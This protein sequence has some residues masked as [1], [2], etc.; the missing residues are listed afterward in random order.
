MTSFSSARWITRCLAAGIVAS[1]GIGAALAAPGELDNGFG[2]AGRVRI[3]PSTPEGGSPPQVAGYAMAQQADGKIVVVGQVQD[4]SNPN[5]TSPDFGVARLNTDGSLDTS[6]GDQGAL[7][8][9]FGGGTAWDTAYAVLIQP[10][11]KIVVAGETLDQSSTYTYDVALVRLNA[12]G[13]LDT[14]FGTGGRVIYDSGGSSAD[15]ATGIVRQTDGSLVIAGNTDR[16]GEYDA[17]FARFTPDGAPDTTFG[18]NGSVTL[19]FGPGSTETVTA[20]VRLS[21]DTLVAA[22]EGPGGSGQQTM[23][24]FRLTKDGQPDTTFSDDGLVIVNFGQSYATARAAVLQTDGKLVLA[25]YYYPSGQ[26]VALARLNTD[27]SLDTDFGS[28]GTATP[29]LGAAWNGHWANGVVVQADGSIV[30]AGGLQPADFNL[31]HDLYLARLQADGTL[32][33]TFGNQ[34]VAIADFGSPDQLSN[35]SANALL[36]Q[37]DG[38]LVAGGTLASGT[39]AIFARFDATGGGSGGVLSFATLGTYTQENAGTI[40]VTLRRTGGGTGPV[41]ASVRVGASASG[42]GFGAGAG[43]D[44]TLGSTTVSWGNGD[45]ADKTIS[46]DIVDDAYV[47]NA[48]NFQIQLFA[49]VGAALAAD[50]HSVYINYDSSDTTDPVVGEI[51]IEATKTVS[52]GAGTV[53]LTVTR[54]NGSQDC[55][56]ADYAAVKADFAQFPAT[57]GVDFAATTGVVTFGEGDTTPKQISI[58]IIEDNVGEADE[59][60]AVQLNTSFPAAGADRALVTIQDND[61][62]YPGTLSFVQGGVMY[63][64]SAGTVQVQLTRQDG[65]NGEVSVN[66]TITSGTATVGVDLTGATSG[67]VT[68]AA[69]DTATKVINVTIV[70]DT[71]EES[72]ETFDITLSGATNGAAVG[73]SATFTGQINDNDTKYPGYFTISSCQPYPLLEG[74]GKAQCQV[75]RDGGKD[76]AVSVSFA[77]ADGT[78]T[79]PADYQAASGTLNWADG[80]GC[81]PPPYSDCN[82]RTKFID[83]PIVDDTDPEPSETFDIVLSNPTNG[84]T[85]Q[86]GG[87]KTTVTIFASD[88]PAGFISMEKGNPYLSVGEAAG[89]IT[90]HALRT[91]GT[92]GQV[93]VTFFTLTSIGS[94]WA[95]DG[96]DFTGVQPPITLTWADGDGSPK[97]VVIPILD[98]ANIEGAEYFYVYLQDATGGAVLDPVYFYGVVQIIDDELNPGTASFQI[99]QT[100]GESV[101]TFNLQVFRVLGSSGAVSVNW[102]ANN[103]T[104]VSP[105]DF[106][107]AGS[108]TLS[109]A[110]GEGGSKLI[111]ITI[112]NDT[113]T[114]PLENFSIVFSGATGGLQL[115][116][117]TATI[118]ILDDD[119][120][121]AINLSPTQQSVTEADTTVTFNATRSG[122]TTGAV[123]VTWA[124]AD[125]TAT[126][127]SDYLQGGATLTWAAGETGS[128]SFSVTIKDD[129]IEELDETFAVTLSNPTGGAELQVA[130][131]TGTI[132]DNDANPGTL[133][134]TVATAQVSEAAGTG[135]VQIDV[136]RVGGSLGAVGVQATTADGTALA[137]S[138]YTAPLV[139]VPLAWADGE[140][141]TRSFTIPITNDTVHEQDEDFTVVLSSPTGG[142]VLGVPSTE[143]VTIQNDDDFNGEFSLDAATASVTEGGQVTLHVTRTNGSYGPVTVDVATANGAAV[144]PD[145]FTAVS[146]T[147]SW[148]AGDTSTRTVTV[149]TV[150]DATDEPAENFA[151][152][153]SNATGGGTIYV[154]TTNVTIQDNDL[155]PTGTIIMG[156]PTI[157]IGE[158][159]S[160]VHIPVGRTGG[161][162]G[163]ATV[164]YTTQD[165]TALAGSDY[166]A[167]SGTLT[168]GDWE[169]AT[170]SIAITINN[171]KIDE[172]DE[173]F[174]VVLSNATG[175][176]LSATD[177]TTAVTIVDDDLPLVPGELTVVAPTYVDENATGVLFTFRRQGGVD[178]IVSVDYATSN[179]TA[180]AGADYTAKSG[181]LTWADGDGADQTVL[182]P[183][184]DDI[185]DEPNETFAMAMSNP[186]GGATLGAS[187]SVTM[188]IVDND[189]SGPGLLGVTGADVFETVGNAVIAVTRGNGFD[190]AVGVTVSTA[191]G[192]ALAGEDYTTTSQVLNWADGEGG[193]KTVSIPITNDSVAE[194]FTENFLVNLSAGTGG[195]T[196]NPA[197]AGVTIRD[198]DAPGTIALTETAVLAAENGPAVQLFV[199]RS[200]GAK[201][202]VSVDFATADGTA[203]AGTDYTSQSGTL[204]WLDGDSSIRTITVPLVDDTKWEVDETF[205]VVLSN[206]SPGAGLGNA[207]ATVTIHSDEV[208]LPGTLRMI[209]PTATVAE[210][211]GTVDVQ[212]ERINGSDGAISVDY[213]TNAGTATAG[214]DY[215]SKSNT[216]T[217]ADGDTATK[218]ITVAILDDAAYEPDET[219]AVLLS[220]PQGGSILAEAS[221]VVTI[222]SEDVAVPGTLGLASATASVNEPAG[223]VTLLVNRTGG[224]DTA[225]SVGYTTASGTA[226]EGADFTHTTGTLNW[227]DGDAAPKAIV[228]PIVDDATYEPVDETFTVTLG[229]VT[230]ATLGTSAATVTIVSDD[231]PQRGTLAMASAAASVNEPDGT[232][233]VLVNRTGGSDGP[234]SVSYATTAGSAG[235]GDYTDTSGTLSWADG[236]SSPKPIAVSITN[237]AIFE[238]DETFT[239]TLSAPDG[240][241]ALGSLATTTVTIV[242]DDAPLGGLIAMAS[243]TASVNEP[244]GTITLNVNRVGGADGAVSVDY[245]T[246]AGTATAGADYTTASGTLS[247]A[248]GDTAAKPITVS[249]GN[250]AKYEPDETFTVTLANLVG[251]GS[252]LGLATTT[253]TIVSEDPVQPGTIAMAA[254]SAVVDETQ[255][256]ITLTVNRT[257]GTDGAVGVNYTMTPV[258][259]SAADFTISSGTL[260]WADGD[261]AAKTI[262]VPITNDTAFEPDETFTVALAGE[263]GGATLGAATTTVTIVSD[264]PA[265]RGTLAL[266]SATATVNEADGTITL[267]VDRTGG[268]DGV[269]SVSYATTAG[270][271]TSADFTAASGTLTWQDGDAATRTIVVQISNDALVEADEAFAVTLSNQTGGA[272]LGRASTTVTI[273]DDDYLTVPGVLTL[274]Q[275]ATTVSETTTTVTFTVTRTGGVG[276]AVSVDY[277]TADGTAAAGSDYTGAAGTLNWPNGDATSRTFTVTL[278][279]DT[280]YE[281]D[282]TF[283]VALSGPTGSVVLGNASATVTIQSEDPPPDTTPEPFSFVDQDDQEL[284]AEIQSNQ[285]AV[286]GINTPVQISITGGEYSVN[287]GPYT[288]EPGT[289]SN[290]A[291]VRVRVNSSANYATT[292][293]ATLTIGGVSDT[294]TVTTRPATSPVTVRAKGGGGSL[295]LLEILFGAGLLLVRRRRV[296]GALASL[297][298]VG[299]ALAAPAQAE[300]GGFY[301]AVGVGQSEVSVSQSEAQG[302][303]E[304]ATGA[305]ITSM[306][307][308]N[309]DTS[310]QGRVGF[311]FNRVF[312]IEAAYYDFGETES[313]INAN[314]L[315]AQEFVDAVADAFP[316]NTHGPA[317]LLRL[318]WPF[319]DKFA[320]EARAGVLMWNSSIDARV[321]NGGSEAAIASRDGTDPIFG[322]GFSWQMGK[323]LGLGLEYTQAQLD[324]EVRSYALTVTW[325]L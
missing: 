256:T 181:T 277:A 245:A 85:L 63:P 293:S 50:T 252:S 187:S 310:F 34:G 308:D 272:T 237:D 313:E 81:P 288:S 133:R 38:R 42:F 82:G 165:F 99:Q 280:A 136:E 271:A 114:E 76:G 52:E 264:D 130:S 315:D 35:A 100:V 294:F 26:A 273:V 283:T 31:A 46:I 64:E 65:S 227:A 125:G 49:P 218:T 54:S 134:F 108:G 234:V 71:L 235:A 119:Y 318:A 40:T 230:G 88:P 102:T 255:G 194:T 128:K 77:T 206:V 221:T 198:D 179:G 33:T 202:T 193:T 200:N 44:F 208:P 95:Q 57:S 1:L 324:D 184:N 36:L 231:P 189:F 168:W 172:P 253:V 199:A 14:S 97:D 104:A 216:L 19:T 16:N 201:G 116:N 229:A 161:V 323:H 62:G 142:A 90:V 58:P 110:A 118:E 69:G 205:D 177:N 270:T 322:V 281:S 129:A 37:T 305:E 295:G 228:V 248:N 127:P 267:N 132:V 215:T 268:T 158:N 186:Q 87:E 53:T 307:F 56:V 105:D 28:G 251:A 60:F 135:S 121:G 139:P 146:Q 68:W 149:D 91:G 321:I 154:D 285:V 111:P 66:Y 4:Y 299:L 180:T 169:Y 207:A 8:I 18:T 211:A 73:Y 6:F 153:L 243:A 96:Q 29:D 182:V 304:A 78:A 222:Q 260:S 147:L 156:A 39:A 183:V 250:D 22:G 25:G 276:G 124:T 162:S 15:R 43:C 171:D 148:A 155:G 61:G 72:A 80:E 10:D 5:N 320:V 143:T 2:I 240:G 266:E 122:G 210:T 238:A 89:S 217:W 92:Q 150:D 319:A 214:S 67:T 287:G 164:D 137:G 236:D 204:T 70:D 300:G 274:T 45:Y 131:A 278:I 27:G 291:T 113:A 84:A 141:G 312:G 302:R 178:G 306:S 170:Q 244:D 83:V 233:T 265:L 223:T 249:I 98:D 257:G 20:L 212:V 144:A 51:G 262:V 163:P 3:A 275:T 239:V 195:V 261:A 225:V 314:V 247:W 259:A 32:D 269:V 246:A 24:A 258:T 175:A 226:T 126:Q 11:G 138:D 301:A 254:A 7:S 157:S 219:F 86:T 303:I 191:D 185:V 290:G 123:S 317:L 140:K 292:V 282:E 151:V 263:T 242:S 101:G 190:G 106:T 197:V 188:L 241:A 12:D 94:N 232:V 298:A 48:D 13:S 286:S 220:N 297:T 120:P 160:V 152:Q 311:A 74:S 279:N 325:K 9:D 296:A 23:A 289:V 93:S 75:S 145:D 55:A 176:A 166:V 316:S 284:D 167:A 203:Q 30:V 224:S 21:D 59:D 47:E 103:G 159:V 117:T 112:V 79:A 115:A 107:S 173:I 41:S 213:V 196:L 17:L 174:S 192:T 109:W 209:A 309:K